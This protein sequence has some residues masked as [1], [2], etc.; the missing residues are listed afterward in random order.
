MSVCYDLFMHPTRCEGMG[1]LLLSAITILV[2]CQYTFGQTC[3]SG[4]VPI[5]SNLGIS[6]TGAGTLNVGIAADLNVLRSLYSGGEKLTD[7]QRQRITQST[8]LRASYSFS[9]RLLLESYLPIVYQSRKIST[10]TQDDLQSS[11]GVGDGILIAI[12]DLVKQPV[13][14]RA[15]LGLQMP[16][17]STTVH[18]GSGLLLVE[19]LQPGSG[20][21]DV[22]GLWQI[23]YQ[24]LASMQAYHLNIMRSQN[25]INEQSRGGTLAYQFGNDWQVTA[26]LSHQFFLVDE[27]WQLGLHLRHRSVHR[28]RI[29][30]QEIAG[31]GG[32]FLFGGVDLSWI[33]ESYRAIIKLEYPIKTR[34]NETQLA[35]STLLHIGF[36]RSINTQKSPTS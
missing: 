21:W 23:Q 22:I 17:G 7:D 3:C 16:L 28:D 35:S 15:G 5:S 36:S 11:F 25:G 6:N 27:I 9:Q 13:Q 8:N 32:A 2:C 19:D 31:T 20:A 34:V 30:G 29:N 14:I 26:G 24:P 12:Y 4:G 10:A 33:D 1:H 18:N